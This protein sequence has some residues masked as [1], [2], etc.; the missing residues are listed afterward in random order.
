V[1]LWYDIFLLSQSEAFD[2]S[3]WCT[4]IYYR[5]GAVLV[6]DLVL[7][8]SHASN[9]YPFPSSWATPVLLFSHFYRTVKCIKIIQIN[10]TSHS[11]STRFFFFL[12]QYSVCLISTFPWKLHFLSTMNGNIWNLVEKLLIQLPHRFHLSFFFLHYYAHSSELKLNYLFMRED[13][14]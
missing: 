6:L 9:Q 10:N 8:V 11:V 13:F 12:F 1:L 3:S 2:T 4:R 7:F 14:Q 5:E